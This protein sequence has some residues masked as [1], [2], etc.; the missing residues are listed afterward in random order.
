M[1]DDEDADSGNLTALHKKEKKQR[2]KKEKKQR[3]KKAWRSP[4][5]RREIAAR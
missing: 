5:D 1:S 3:H 4:G 2:H